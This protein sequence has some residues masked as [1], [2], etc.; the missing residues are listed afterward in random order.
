MRKAKKMN[1]PEKTRDGFT[2]IYDLGEIPEF[3]SEAEEQAFWETHTFSD[4]LMDDAAKEQHT[5][6]DLPPKR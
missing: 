1:R 6:F 5:P 2:I 4:E 3:K